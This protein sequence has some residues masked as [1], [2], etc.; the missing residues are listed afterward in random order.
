MSHLYQP[1]THTIGPGSGEELITIHDLG[2]LTEPEIR[3]LAGA[4]G[5]GGVGGVGPVGPAGVAGPAGATGARGV[6]GA[7]G[8]KGD[9]GADGST[10]IVDASK[11]FAMDADDSPP[12]NVTA[13][14]GADAVLD[15]LN[16]NVSWPTGW[17]SAQLVV[18]TDSQLASSIGASQFTAQMLVNNVQWGRVQTGS[19]ADGEEG[20]FAIGGRGLV[21]RPFNIKLRATMSRDN[22]GGFRAHRYTSWMYFL[23]R[24]S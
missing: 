17:G 22:N 5:V 23:V 2:G 13:W 8:Q 18:Y 19:F 21:S 20:H 11:F 10:S 24:T 6:T 3:Q 9:T 7:Q 15:V 12:V 1:H 14:K 4:D 16:Q